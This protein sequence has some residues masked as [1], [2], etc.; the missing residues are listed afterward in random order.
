MT[1]VII[2][3]AIVAVLGIAMIKLLAHDG[4]GPQRPPTSH[5]PDPQFRSPWAA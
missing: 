3:L 5:A 1:S 2:L 4:R